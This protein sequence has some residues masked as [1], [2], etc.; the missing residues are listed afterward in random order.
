MI[1]HSERVQCVVWI[2]QAVASG[3]RK[4]KASD[5]VGITLRTLQNWQ[6][7]GDIRA[8]KRPDAVRP[9]PSNKLTPKVHILTHHEHRF[10]SMVNAHYYPS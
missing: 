6:V 2:N 7:N 3:A 9:E 5:V 1:P 10:L 8:D 4:G